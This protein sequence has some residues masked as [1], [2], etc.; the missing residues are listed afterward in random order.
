MIED[1]QDE[2]RS[3]L[4]YIDFTVAFIDVKNAI[5]NGENPDFC[6]PGAKITDIGKALRM[7][8]NK[9]YHPSYSHPDPMLEGVFSPHYGM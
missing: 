1:A 6:D 5:S 8:F 7:V 2:I 3:G 4:F 9:Y